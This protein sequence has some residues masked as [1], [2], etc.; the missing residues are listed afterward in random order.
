[1]GRTGVSAT[2]VLTVVATAVLSGCDTDE[3][4]EGPDRRALLTGGRWHT[5]SV[6]VIEPDDYSSEVEVPAWVE[7]DD[8]G[9]VRSAPLNGTGESDSGQWRFIDDQDSIV[10]EAGD[11][12][13]EYKILRLTEESL[14]YRYEFKF[15][16]GDPIVGVELSHSD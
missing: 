4:D 10:V 7:F 11:I 6:E 14:R 16:E 5:E 9:T 12:T 2:L 13:I 1:M 3:P 8:D 15:L